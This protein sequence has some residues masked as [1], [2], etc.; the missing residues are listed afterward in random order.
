M[1]LLWPFYLEAA[2]ATVLFGIACWGAVALRRRY[3]YVLFG[4][5]WFVVSLLPVVGI[6]QV[7]RQ[8]MADRYMYIPSIGLFIILAWG[9]ADLLRALR[10]RPTVGY[11][12][13]LVCLAGCCLITW[14]QVGFG[15]IALP[16]SSEPWQSPAAT[17]SL[18]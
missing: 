9:A 4:W 6:V 11:R 5:L 12:A 14:R 8:A 15:V 13:A 18:R 3:P 10:W 16:C 17:T 1:H 2:I 7:G